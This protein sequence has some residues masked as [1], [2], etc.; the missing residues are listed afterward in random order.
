M[1]MC[2]YGCGRD[3]E[4]E[5]PCEKCQKDQF[6]RDKEDASLFGMLPDQRIILNIHTAPITRENIENALYPIDSSLN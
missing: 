3:F 1:A 4:T 2:P 6:E 5:D